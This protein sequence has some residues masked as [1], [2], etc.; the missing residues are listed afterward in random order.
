[1]IE[2]KAR[3]ALGSQ[4]STAPN[5]ILVRLGDD[6]YAL[7]AADGSV[8]GYGDLADPPASA[9]GVPTSSPVVGLTATSVFSEVASYWTVTA[10]GTVLGYCIGAFGSLP[11]SRHRT[12]IV[13]ILPADVPSGPGYWIV[14]AGGGVF[15]YGH[16]R[17]HGVVN[18]KLAAPI[19]A[20]VP[21]PDG[22]GYYM[23]SS[24]GSVFTFGDAVDHGSLYHKQFGGSVV[25]IMIDPSGGGYWLVTSTGG[26]FRFGNAEK[27][28]SL[29]KAP[30]AP[31]IKAAAT[32]DGG[33]FWL[34]EAN[35]TVQTVGD[36]L[37]EGNP[38]GNFQSHIVAIS[39]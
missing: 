11:A 5:P 26:I 15:P 21:T 24:N 1:M 31:V 6:G 33:G 23:A 30:A 27:I 4:I 9:S 8:F 38:V 13:A 22:E 37:F 20:A 14:T 12:P 18:R 35:G 17:T 7:A 29:S 19:V 28:S 25:A 32:P 10:A 34:L 3:N 36:A 16:A 39:I 2:V